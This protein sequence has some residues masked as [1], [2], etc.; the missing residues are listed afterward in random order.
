[1]AVCVYRR[2]FPP[3]ERSPIKPRRLVIAS[4]PR[5][6]EPGGKQSRLPPLPTITGLLRRFASRNDD[7]AWSKTAL[8]ATHQATTA[9]LRAARFVLA[10]L[11]AAFM[12]TLRPR[13]S[14]F[15]RLDLCAA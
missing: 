1:M 7:P 4:D 6:E 13:P 14:D 15:A 9:A 12:P 2:S 8:I 5:V 10:F 3:L 11:A